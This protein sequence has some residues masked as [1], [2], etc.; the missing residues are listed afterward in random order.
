MK[1]ANI[2]Y[3]YI[4][5]LL[6]NNIVLYNYRAI[7]V[8]YFKYD[9]CNSNQT[10]GVIF[11]ILPLLAYVVC[12]NTLYAHTPYSSFFWLC[13]L[14]LSGLVWWAVVPLRQYIAFGLIMSV[15]IQEA[16][17]VAFFYVIKLVPGGISFL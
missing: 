5:N 15:L 12:T 9:L 1:N 13:A 4:Y 14:L 8:Q 2:I 7:Q 11:D 17:R 3:I 16:A 10:I 6:N